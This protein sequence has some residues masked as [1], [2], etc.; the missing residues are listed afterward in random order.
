MTFFLHTII[1]NAFLTQTPDGKAIAFVT[2]NWRYGL[3]GAGAYLTLR[4]VANVIDTYRWWR[5]SDD[6]RVRAKLER[7]LAKYN[8]A[9]GRNVD[10][11]NI[12]QQLESERERNLLVK[13]KVIKRRRRPRGSRSRS[14][15][16]SRSRSRSYYR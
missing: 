3:Y 6:A 8:A 2:K 10:L 12:V 13:K 14:R 1:V 4:L 9:A 15:R 16:V 11:V 7:E 5:G